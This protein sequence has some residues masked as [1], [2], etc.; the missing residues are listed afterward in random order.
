MTDALPWCFLYVVDQVGRNRPDAVLS[1]VQ[2]E[3]TIWVVGVADL[4]TVCSTS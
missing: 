2:T 3:A 4:I 1:P